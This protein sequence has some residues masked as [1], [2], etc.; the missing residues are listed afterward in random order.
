M[1][2]SV[3]SGAPLDPPLPDAPSGPQI[4]N[5]WAANPLHAEM[6]VNDTRPRCELFVKAGVDGPRP[7]RSGQDHPLGYWATVDGGRRMVISCEEPSAHDVV[8]LLGEHLDDMRASS[9]SE[10]IHALGV[11][12]LRSPAVTF[13]TARLEGTLL[14]CGALMELSPVEGEIKSM[15]TAASFRG[16]GVATALLE[17]IVAEAVRRGYGRLCVETG[18]QDFFA[19]ARRLY[20]RH[21]FVECGP[22]SDYV[23]DPNSV[24]MTRSLRP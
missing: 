4:A 8:T 1:G 23:P 5:D 24:F 10:S 18:S 21:G 17:G 6:P 9:R 3:R 13:W 11:E 14:G 20:L 15:R 22:F 7:G 12:D 2:V 19:P 16:H